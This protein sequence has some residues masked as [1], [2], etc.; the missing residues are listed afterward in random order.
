[1]GILS[2]AP[3]FGPEEDMPG[4]FTEE[5]AALADSERMVSSERST[6]QLASPSTMR[7]PLDVIG[8]MAEILAED[9]QLQTLAALN[10][11]SHLVHE[12]TLPA[13]YHSVRV[14][15]ASNFDY[16]VRDDLPRGWSYTK[17]L[18][19]DYGMNQSDPED[20][21]FAVLFPQLVAD[22]C[23]QNYVCIYNILD[24]LDE[25]DF[26]E[27]R[28]VFS[29]FVRLYAEHTQH[30][31]SLFGMDIYLL[32]R[33]MTSHRDMEIYIKSLAAIY[34]RHWMIVDRDDAT[35]SPPVIVYASVPV[36]EQYAV[37][38]EPRFGVL[39]GLLEIDRANA[40]LIHHWSNNGEQ[41]I[42]QLDD[43]E[44][45]IAELIAPTDDP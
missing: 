29:T 27:E 6:A 34:E 44:H 9:C 36:P 20:M 41:P 30:I 12:E 10:R 22:P 13:L 19:D 15:L 31:P 38:A 33:N 25:V 11:T 23:Y 1:M 45:A 28:S 7:L 37:A 16:V 5:H 4:Q 18:E 26:R 42:A 21:D 35:S 2:S 32:G 14:P 39:Q 43:H 3:T 24:D 17:N 40:Q 8:V